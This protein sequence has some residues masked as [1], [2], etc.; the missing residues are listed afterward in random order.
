MKIFLCNISSFYVHNVPEHGSFFEI[1]IMM[2]GFVQ[3]YRGFVVWCSFYKLLT[4][5]KTTH[6]G[7]TGDRERGPYVFMAN[8]QS[9]MEE[10]VRS[11]R[12]VIGAPTSGGSI[13]LLNRWCH[14][15]LTE[16]YKIPLNSLIN[17]LYKIWSIRT[18]TAFPRLCAFLSSD[19]LESLLFVLQNYDLQEVTVTVTERAA[20][21]FC[22]QSLC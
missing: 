16:D 18:K 3:S 5:T 11:L 2:C 6:T 4:T 21:I 12:R 7:K 22:L 8:S 15:H 17:I 1:Y 20:D 10:W 14:C 13:K 9:D 19:F